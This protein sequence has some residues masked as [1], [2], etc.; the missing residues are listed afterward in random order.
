M[1][2]VEK[3]A[4]LIET[5]QLVHEEDIIHQIQKCS[6]ENQVKLKQAKNL[7]DL[8][9]IQLSTVN[10]M[11][12]DNNLFWRNL[13]NKNENF[14]KKNLVMQANSKYPKHD[15]KTGNLPLN[16]NTISEDKEGKVTK[17]KEKYY[18]NNEYRI[19]NGQVKGL[20]DFYGKKDFQPSQKEIKPIKKI[21]YKEKH[22]EALNK[23]GKSLNM[24]ENPIIKNEL[25]SLK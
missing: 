18:Q 5:R 23:L 7:E 15:L 10:S 16:H 3:A 8:V 4:E 9:K 21:I 14:Q 1:N 17:T 24:Y 6:N 2:S 19:E 22:E 13:I 25:S 11:K 20:K 12:K